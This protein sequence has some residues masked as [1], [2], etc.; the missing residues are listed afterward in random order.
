MRVNR[1][2]AV[3]FVLVLAG[4]VIPFLMVVKVL[5][6]NLFLSLFSYAASITG[7]FLGV[8]GAAYIAVER[9]RRDDTSN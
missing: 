3:G 6:P 5:P 8:I 2:I 1:I 7:L 9:S 4:A